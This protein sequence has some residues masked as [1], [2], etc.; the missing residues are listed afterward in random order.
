[1]KV[2]LV[3]IGTGA[4]AKPAA[5]KDPQPG[6]PQRAGNANDTSRLPLR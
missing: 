2:V 3:A 5:G 1:M 6:E 4:T